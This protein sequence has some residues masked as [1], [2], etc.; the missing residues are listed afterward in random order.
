MAQPSPASPDQER[1]GSFEVIDS[2]SMEYLPRVEEVPGWRLSGDPLVYPG[3]ELG[4]YIGRQAEQYLEYEIQDATI[5]QYEQT[6]GEGLATV[7]IYRFPDFVKAFGAFSSRKSLARK[8]LELANE[9]FLGSYSAHVWRGPFYLRVVG[10]EIPEEDLI[11]IT[12][13]VV[14]RMPP[15][16]GIPAVFQ[17]LPSENRLVRSER[18]SAGP[19]FGQPYLAGGFTADYTV[20][21]QPIEGA[22]IP[23]PSKEVASEILDRYRAFFVNNGRLL[24]RIPNLGEDNLTAEDRYMGRTIA[25]RLDRFVVVF[26]SF[27]PIQDLMPLAIGTDQRILNS[28]RVQL[29]AADRAARAQ[30]LTTGSSQPRRQSE[31]ASAASPP[32]PAPQTPAPAPETTPENDEPVTS[33]DTPPPAPQEPPT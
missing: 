13:A 19:V 11:G 14:D 7:E 8:P 15:A 21:D 32:A 31:P 4:S 6:E 22:I 17:F 2:P 16:P 3:A 28:I 30:G 1:G 33:P 26:R 27:G 29:Q 18:Y 9:A 10:S 12:R 20:N 24:D 5:G 25:F 23:A